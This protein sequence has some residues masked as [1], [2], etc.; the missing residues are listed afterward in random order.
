MVGELAGNFGR[1]L[2]DVD[3]R[4]LIVNQWSRRK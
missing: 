1:G 3:S 4:L 2:I